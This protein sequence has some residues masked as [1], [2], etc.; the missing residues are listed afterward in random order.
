MRL[1][2]RPVV[3]ILCAAIAVIAF[4]GVAFASIPTPAS[5]TVTLDPEEQS[6]LDQLNVERTR[7]RSEGVE[8]IARAAGGR[9]V[10]GERHDRQLDSNQPVAHG[11]VV[12]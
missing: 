1:N 9:R 7:P 2:T 8:G 11:L 3:H 12:P 4:A 6:A 5:A 10:D